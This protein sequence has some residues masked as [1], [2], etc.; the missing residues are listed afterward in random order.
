MSV[1]IRDLKTWAERGEINNLY[2]RG[3]PVEKIAT[4]YRDYSINQLEEIIHEFFYAYCEKCKSS[5]LYELKKIDV[6]Q[7]INGEDFTCSVE[8]IFCKECGSE[9]EH[10]WF[11]VNTRHCIKDS[12]RMAKG[13]V[14]VSDIER[15]R[16]GFGVSPES[17]S[18]ALGFKAD[19]IE[20]YLDGELPTKIHS[21]IIKR[22]L[23]E[24]EFFCE[25]IKENAEQLDTLGKSILLSWAMGFER[26][27]RR[28]YEEGRKKGEY[29]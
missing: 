22:A 15:I 7:V 14:S 17:L 23:G 4:I 11:T 12:Y 25:K 27:Y 1:Y 9:V 29:R 8:K 24:P 3:M 21:D 18:L 13:L 16:K 10:E 20:R 5:Q 6:V 2:K 19:T 28:A 26:S